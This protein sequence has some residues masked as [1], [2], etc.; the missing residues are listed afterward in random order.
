ME[1]F[2]GNFTISIIIKFLH[3]LVLFFLGNFDTHFGETGR[4][5][6]EGES[7]TAIFVHLSEDETAEVFETAEFLSTL[8]N[9]LQEMI[10]INFGEV[11]TSLVS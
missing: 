8:L 2:K 10:Y 1:L 4:Q 5:L 9:S 6:I 3:E 7:S 11:M